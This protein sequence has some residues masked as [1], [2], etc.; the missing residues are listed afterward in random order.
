MNFSLFHL[1]QPTPFTRVTYVNTEGQ[2]TQPTPFTRVTD[3]NSERQATEK[4]HVLQIHL[5]QYFN[6]LMKKVK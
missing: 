6:F 4:V 1:H 3:V 5:L 2:T